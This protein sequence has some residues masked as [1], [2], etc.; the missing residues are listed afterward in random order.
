MNLKKIRIDDFNIFLPSEW[1]DIWDFNP[2][3]PPT[4]V[5]GRIEN[6]R[7]L[8]ISTAK[9]VSGEKPN[10]DF[11][12]LIQLSEPHQHSENMMS[13]QDDAKQIIELVSKKLEPLFL[14]YGF[15]HKRRYS[16][17]PIFN[18]ILGYEKGNLELRISACLHPHDYPN[19]LD[20]RM[21]RK[22]PG[23][24]EYYNLP[25]LLTLIENDRTFAKD[26][27]MIDPGIRFVITLANIYH[28]CECVLKNVIQEK[29]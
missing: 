7:V 5:D 22:I 27:F 16:D 3:G 21:I 17:P 20:V 28:F 18:E 4:F 13:L 14:R 1:Q 8:Q 15:T 24:W 6:P 25:D 26:D 2:D 23:N 12:D 19:T 11:Q 10:S 29:S 9:Y